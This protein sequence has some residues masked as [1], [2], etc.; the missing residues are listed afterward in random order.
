[1]VEGLLLQ[2]SLQEVQSL[3]RALL[4]RTSSCHTQLN[5]QGTNVPQNQVQQE[6]VRDQTFLRIS[7]NS[8]CHFQDGDD[9]SEV[10][11]G[12]EKKAKRR[13]ETEGSDAECRV[14]NKKHKR[15]KM[16]KKN[17]Q[18]R[19]TSTSSSPRSDFSQS[20]DTDEEMAVCPADMCQQPEGD[21]VSR[22]SGLRSPQRR[23]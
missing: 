19:L 9:T 12:S 6:K 5:S 14:K 10:L 7:L 2:V 11:P 3:Y 23:T 15:R 22:S 8:C 20:D 21:E 18:H 13:M 17:S 16:N 4:D 1:M